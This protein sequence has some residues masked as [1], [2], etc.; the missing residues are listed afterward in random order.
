M[1]KCNLCLS[2]WSRKT[3]VKNTGKISRM[4]HLY[5]IKAVLGIFNFFYFIFFAIGQA[6]LKCDVVNNISVDDEEQNLSLSLDPK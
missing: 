2:F 5:I 1:G 4:Y 6:G 3:F